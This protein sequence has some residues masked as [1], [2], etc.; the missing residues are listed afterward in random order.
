MSEM[1][2]ALAREFEFMAG[3]IE[4]LHAGAGVEG[5]DFGDM[6]GAAGGD[7]GGFVRWRDGEEEF[8]V[9]A[10]RQPGFQMIRSK[11]GGLGGSG[12]QGRLDDRA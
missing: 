8:V 5:A 4:D 11:R 9:V 2:P 6:Q 12:D 7:E 3:F 1:P 10:I